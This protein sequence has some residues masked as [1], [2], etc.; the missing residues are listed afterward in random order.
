MN[1]CILGGWTPREMSH[2]EYQ[3]EQKY[4]STADLLDFSSLKGTIILLE[5]ACV[6]F[7]IIVI[8]PFDARDVQEAFQ[9]RDLFGHDPSG[10]DEAQEHTLTIPSQLT[11][12]TPH[13]GTN[14]NLIKSFGGCVFF[15]RLVV[16]DVGKEE[17]RASDKVISCGRGPRSD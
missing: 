13:G 7:L 1:A 6:H 8:R 12:E 5:S 9:T 17:Q 4:F 10:Q 3:I 2:K 16:V 15:V 11:M 14:E